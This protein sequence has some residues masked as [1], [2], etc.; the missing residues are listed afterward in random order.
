MDSCWGDEGREG[1]EKRVGGSE[2][3]TKR[4]RTVRGPATGH[5]TALRRRATRLRLLVWRANVC[6]VPDVLVVDRVAARNDLPKRWFLTTQR[7]A[8]S[9]RTCSPPTLEVLLH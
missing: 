2:E 1:G 5:C 3:E 7:R 4:P 8:S 9:P 6:N